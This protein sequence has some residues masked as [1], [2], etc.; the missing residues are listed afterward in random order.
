[1]LAVFLKCGRLRAVF[2]RDPQWASS[3][4][5]GVRRPVCAGGVGKGVFE[6]LTLCEEDYRGVPY[7]DARKT[8]E[9]G[10]E[11]LTASDGQHLRLGP[12]Q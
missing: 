1:M 9:I 3:S 11:D 6:G 7:S 5:R 2:S 12:N 10:R 8:S 4:R